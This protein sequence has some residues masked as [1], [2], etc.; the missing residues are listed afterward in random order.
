MVL[1]RP[2]EAQSVTGWGGQAG[3]RR[4]VL[5][6]NEPNCTRVRSGS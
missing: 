5:L 4:I 6:Q 1:L 2:P 3:E